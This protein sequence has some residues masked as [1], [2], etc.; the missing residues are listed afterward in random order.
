[1]LTQLRRTMLLGLLVAV[2]CGDG[3][4]NDNS[5]SD[6]QDRDGS[7]PSRYD[8]WTLL[9]LVE[10]AEVRAGEVIR[11]QCQ[12]RKS[13]E[14][15]RL[16]TVITVTPAIPDLS[17]DG[18]VAIYT[19]SA[20]G[21]YHFSCS[22]SD[23]LLADDAGVNVDVVP[24]DVVTV[25]TQLGASTSAAG[26]AVSVGCKAYDGFGNSVTD[27]RFTIDTTAPMVVMSGSVTGTIVGDY[28]IACRVGD[29]ADASPSALTIIGAAVSRV[30][31]AVS[32]EYVGPR[33]SVSV[34]C[35][36]FDAFGNARQDVARRFIVLPEDGMSP[37]R[38]GIVV[39]GNTF[40]VTH[41]AAYR[42]IC[43]TFDGDVSDVSPAIVTVHPALPY[44]AEVALLQQDCYWAGRALPMQVY[45]QDA[46]ENMIS[47][48]PMHVYTIPDGGVTSD[49]AGGY[50]V[51]GEADYDLYVEVQGPLAPD[52]RISTFIHNLRVDST[53]PHLE[54]SSPARGAMVRSG[55]L[56]ASPVQVIGRVYDGLS[57]LQSATIDGVP[58]TISGSPQSITISQAHMSAWGLSVISGSATDECGNRAMFSQSFLRSP[59]YRAPAVRADAAA[60]VPQAVFGHLEQAL[61]DDGDRSDLDD[62]ASLAE[63][64]AGQTDYNDMLDDPLV[65]QPDDNNDGRIDDKNYRCGTCQ[66][67]FDCAHITNKATGFRARTAGLLTNDAPR[68]NSIQFVEGGVSVDLSISNVR[69]PLSV[70]T[71]QDNGCFG[72]PQG[73]I[74]AVVRLG[75]VH[76]IAKLNV[77]KSG[78]VATASLC[79]ECLSIVYECSGDR[80]CP[81]VDIDWGI[82]QFMADLIL[83]P[84]KDGVIRMMQGHMHDMVREQLRAQIPTMVA[85]T[86][87]TFEVARS[88]DMKIPGNP[89]TLNVSSAI[90]TVT[91]RGARANP[92]SWG[93]GELALF[94]QSFP[95]QKAAYLPVGTLGSISRGGPALDAIPMDAGQTFGIAIADDMVNQALWALWYGG[96]AH[97]TDASAFMTPEE[98]LEQ[99]LTSPAIILSTNLPPVIMPGD[100]GRHIQIGMG[101][102]YLEADLDLSL[103]L[104]QQEEDG[105]PPPVL[106]N[107]DS[108]LMHIGMY[109][110]LLYSATM[111]FDAATNKLQ[112][113]IEPNPQTYVQVVTI[114]D[115]GYQG[116]L[117][118]AMMQAAQIMLPTML[119][120]AV[121]SIEIPEFDLSNVAD[122]PEGTVW[123]LRHG[124]ISR[125]PNGNYFFLRGGIH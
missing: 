91:F 11:V 122:L 57:P 125:S 103:I 1:M 70:D 13:G 85:D 90:D 50:V 26:V 78:N 33:E 44:R 14:L 124:S 47:D 74:D 96:G 48:A 68:I 99:G 109:V 3:S 41:A 104:A 98:M 108:N 16:P 46:Y 52:H 63:Y 120:D 101:D 116:I 22:T 35:A 53:P 84:L 23:R 42:V 8:G 51:H 111:D 39:D 36:A 94:M 32:V 114:D 21:A 92:A 102:V 80:S 65:V 45:V 54:I 31:T 62:I 88:M 93:S 17:S 24:N 97:V 34:A 76:A 59:S 117:S 83:N 4:S 60:A 61:L 107:P 82:F 27:A 123:A 9:T 87:N 105:Q 67:G 119:K 6:T 89:I 106:N 100:D 86:L 55:D 7:R 37:R 30:E 19:P 12:T 15:A 29:V 40:S 81:A 10:D 113:Q 71:S 110:S 28:R 20:S 38:A 121:A 79:E 118:D 58:L 49:G 73:N 43:S 75:R 95:S 115:P 64:V 2:G 66:V 72:N 25:E 112:L 69:L 56:S 5:P 18:D 77:A